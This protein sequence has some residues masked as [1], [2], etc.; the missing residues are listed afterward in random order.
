MQPP[1]F[2]VSNLQLIKNLRTLVWSQTGPCLELQ[3]W[4]ETASITMWESER[5]SQSRFCSI[6]N[7]DK[8][9][10]CFLSIVV[11]D[12]ESTLIGLPLKWKEAV[13]SHLF[14][15]CYPLPFRAIEPT[16]ISDTQL[17]RHEGKYLE[18]SRY[19]TLSSRCK[20]LYLQKKGKSNHAQ[21]FIAVESTHSFPLA[22]KSIISEEHIL[23]YKVM[24][25]SL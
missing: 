24:Q 9:W 6:V 25:I 4:L 8:H 1:A 14:I 5:G 7:P 15:W 10:D 20:M 12:N 17:A 23:D 21:L 11:L 16:S 3:A 19:S 22:I 13:R 18:F 2:D